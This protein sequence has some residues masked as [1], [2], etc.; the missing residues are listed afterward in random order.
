MELSELALCTF[1]L[2]INFFVEFPELANATE[3][4]TADRFKPVKPIWHCDAGDHQFISV[5][6]GMMRISNLVNLSRKLVGFLT[7]HQLDSA[8][9]HFEEH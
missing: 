6:D 3:S 9:L 5:S 7:A 1:P 2:F 4:W 8:D